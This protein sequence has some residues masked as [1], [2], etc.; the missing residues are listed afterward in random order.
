MRAV[1]QN[2]QS[3]SKSNDYGN[4]IMQANYLNMCL[5]ITTLSFKVLE[6]SPAL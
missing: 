2:L 3:S 4:N 5:Q 6:T 1:R